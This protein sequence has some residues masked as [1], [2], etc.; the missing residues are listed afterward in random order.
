MKKFF[1][2]FLLF[3]CFTL[4]LPHPKIA[5]AVCA[6]PS[7][8]VRTVDS[9]NTGAYTVKAIDV[10]E[11]GDVDV[12]S[13]G[14]LGLYWYDNNGS[15]VFTKK[16]VDFNNTDY[17]GM[18][19]GD[20]DSDGD[21]DIAAIDR[22][23]D[24]VIWF[25]NNGSETFSKVTPD[26]N[27]DS[28]SSIQIIDLDDDT[29]KDFVVT[30][31]TLHDVVW[32]NNNG[33][34]TFTKTT[35]DSTNDGVWSAY[36]ADVNDDGD[37]DIVAV[38]QGINGTVSFYD[39]NGTETFTENVLF[40][41]SRTDVVIK[42]MDG[43]TDED[44]AVVGESALEWYNNNGSE[45]FSRTSIATNFVG[46]ISIDMA[47]VDADGD[48]DLMTAG[49]TDGVSWWQNNGSQTFAEK[50]VQASVDGRFI[51]YADVDGDT[52]IDM[53]SAQYAQSDVIWYE[54]VCDAT[55]PTVST[56]SSDKANGAYAAGT[57]IDI[58]VTFSE[59][60][61]STGS[62][63]ITLE[64]GDTDRTCTFTVSNSTTGTCNY[65]IQAG[66]TSS[67]LTVSSISGTIK[68]AALNSM[69]NY[70]PASNLAANKALV[71]D[72][73]A[74]LVSSFSPTNGA[75]GIDF[76]SSL[77]INFSENVSVVTGNIGIY[78]VS[79]GT[80]VEN[81]PVGDARVTGSGTSI[82]T[83]NPNDS[84]MDSSGEGYYLLIDS[85]CFD[86][87]ATNGYAGVAST[88]TWRFKTT[89]LSGGR[90]TTAPKLTELSPADGAVDVS[91]SPDF[92]MTFNE[93]MFFKNGY[94]NIYEASSRTLVESIY[95]HSEQVTWTRS[96]WIP[97]K[98]SKELEA[99]KSYYILVDPS[100]LAD[101]YGNYF[102]GLSD[103]TT[104]SFSVAAEETAE[105]DEEDQGAS[106]EE[107][108][109]E[110][111]IVTVTCS[112]L[113]IAHWASSIINTLMGSN[114]YPYE[115]NSGNIICEPQK[116]ITRG[117]LVDWLVTSN[118]QEEF[119]SYAMPATSIF[120][121]LSEEHEDFDAI[122]FAHD[123]GIVSGYP[124][125]SF[126]PDQLVNRAEALKIILKSL[127]LF[128]G[129]TE[130]LDWLKN[131]TPSQDPKKLFSDVDSEDSWYYPYL[132]FASA[133]NVIGG[134]DYGTGQFV[135]EMD[136]PITKSELAKILSLARA[137]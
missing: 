124:D 6:D 64:T 120:S 93:Y 108:A 30:S 128:E 106:P 125:G 33:T 50:V 88:S 103:S 52:D 1:A 135:A 118:F 22:N 112:D 44:I 72:T 7:F 58:D 73:T 89:P 102:T 121:D 49:Y 51:H 132:Y 2:L 59:V 4:Y 42:D 74:P 27:F 85:T 65:T 18:D 92:M 46:G 101:E 79:G 36:A 26:G 116:F 69:T 8:T 78:K 54:Q 45:S 105:G 41:G 13:A 104:W 71:V 31:N 57:V 114:M 55:P 86:D 39:N 68:D 20:V 126:K 23:A 40:T 61:T 133:N 97:F 66:D 19:V 127:Q 25:N 34:Q 109:Q 28:P 80:L 67:D 82:I 76:D 21:I 90:D 111:T 47:D 43:D 5:R 123:F 16:T 83:V 35:I 63:T 96:T 70:V 62:V 91:T 117:E 95:I 99:G 37:K 134:R 94:I 15:E 113:E 17:R 137:L 24:D 3:F 81:I 14:A 53:V 87:V 32:Y 122:S 110:D 75:T 29:D 98:L 119:V 10:D 129:S 84:L 115:D 56:V 131:L 9:G 11:D 48:Q 38:G 12:V 107:N 100:A 60:V 77:T 130:E 136:F